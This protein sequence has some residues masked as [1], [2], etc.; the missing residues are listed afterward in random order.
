MKRNWILAII[1]LAY[2][3]IIMDTSVI[4]TSLDTMRRDL[5]LSVSASTWV[6]DAYTL[7]FGGL[8]VLGAQIGTVLG[9]RRIF[10]AGLIIFGI[11]SVTVGLGSAPGMLIIS[12]AFQGVGA[13]IIAPTSLS[14]IAEHFPEGEERAR[15]TRLYG[16]AAGIGTA[17]GMIIGGLVTTY[18]SWRFA[19]F[20][21]APIAILLIAI[22]LRVLPADPRRTAQEPMSF[23]ILGAFLAT[24]GL[25]AISF[26]IME[27]MWWI[28]IVGGLIV[29]VFAWYE[30]R[31]THP[32]IPPAIINHAVRGPMGL[33][34]FFFAA[35]AIPFFLIASQFMVNHYGLS[36]LAIGLAFSANAVPQFIVAM[37]LRRIQARIGIPAS[38]IGG[39]LMTTI[40]VAAMIPLNSHGGNILVVLGIYAWM[41][42][43]QGLAFATL[44]ALGI[45][46]A[47]AADSGAASGVVN[48]A[49]QLGST[50]GLPIVMSMHNPFIGS[51]VLII[52]SLVFAGWGAL[53]Y[54]AEQ[55]QKV[56]VAV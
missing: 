24:V 22:A 50:I 29:A 33:G 49:Q 14:L 13:A 19:F 43:G 2:F 52:L 4:F 20:I 7:F 41:G 21:N 37:N 34:R 11:S 53:N 56:A 17:V 46:G 8:L 16:A 35:T 6:Q 55:R 42:V 9:K 28:S 40:G 44:T 1:I 15:A 47:S 39:L 5:G 3:M 18:I 25:G 23:D 45:Y 31:A 30:T 27:K 36:P 32:I 51:T 48:S 12:R 26:G 38:V 54:V 10:F